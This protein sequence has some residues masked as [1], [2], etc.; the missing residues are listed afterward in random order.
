MGATGLEEI[1]QEFP[2][3]SNLLSNAN[4]EE[5]E[6]LKRLFGISSPLLGPGPTRGDLAMRTLKYVV[7]ELV[8]KPARKDKNAE[9]PTLL[10]DKKVDKKSQSSVTEQIEIEVK[11]EE[12]GFQEVRKICRHYANNKCKRRQTCS[13]AHPDICQIYSKFGPLRESNPKGCNSKLCD[14]LHAKSKWCKRAVKSNKCMSP[15]CRFEH[16]KGVLTL[17]KLNSNQNKE[18]QRPMPQ[19]S[20][21]LGMK[22]PS[23]AQ[24]T[25]EESSKKLQPSTPT[26]TTFL[27]MEGLGLQHVL[28]EILDKMNQLEKKIHLVASPSISTFLH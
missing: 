22:Q 18:F 26:Q 28:K 25:R 23:Y 5:R 3:L 4:Y 24:V 27:G 6:V 8:K 16:F 11:P 12:I 20:H 19:M 10:E 1:C 13:F 14:L 21:N 2:I 15:K 17:E 7:E 9:E